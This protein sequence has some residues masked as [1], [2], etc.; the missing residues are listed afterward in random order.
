MAWYKEVKKFTSCY[1]SLSLSPIFSFIFSSQSRCTKDVNGLHVE[2]NHG[3]SGCTPFLVGWIQI[4]IL[5]NPMS[6]I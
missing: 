6:L 5:H 3:V 1:A 2:R 4:K